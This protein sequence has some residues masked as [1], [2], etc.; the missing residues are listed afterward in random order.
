VGDED[1]VEEQ[2]RAEEDLEPEHP[3]RSGGGL[4]RTFGVWLIV[5][6]PSWSEWFKGRAC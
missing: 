5:L 1:G 3:R 2:R 6:R 4:H